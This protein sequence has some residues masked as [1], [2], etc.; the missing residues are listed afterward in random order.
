MSDVSSGPDSERDPVEE[1]ADEFVGRLRRGEWPALTEYTRRYREWAERIRK[2]F[3]AVALVEGIR[4]GSDEATGPEAGG[5]LPA[6][7]P[8]EWL[9]DYRVLREVGRGGMGV[10]YEAVQESLGRHVALRVLP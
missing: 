2:V 8:L 4:P 3:P 7:R 9:G 10:V 6:G 5:R 1:L